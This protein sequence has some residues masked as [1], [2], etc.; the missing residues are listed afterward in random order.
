MAI[1]R[2]RRIL[3]SASFFLYVVGAAIVAYFLLRG[4]SQAVQMAALVFVAGLLTVAA[5]ENML[6]EAHDASTDNRRSLLAFIG[7]FALFTVA[8]T[9]LGTLVAASGS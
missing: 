5:A 8:S 4:T 1:S 2:L 7:G 6:Q 3:L 9:G